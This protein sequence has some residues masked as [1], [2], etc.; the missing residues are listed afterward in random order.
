MSKSITI[1]LT[2][3][4][5]K[6]GPFT[7]SDQFGNI[8]AQDVPKKT[9]IAGVTYS[10]DD[11]VTLIIVKSV[12]SCKVEKTI[13]L[14][15]ITTDQFANVTFSQTTT[16]CIWRHLTNI[17]IYN[18]FYGNIE[19][20]IIEYPFAYSY[21]DEI[22][23]N[24]K[25]YTK[26]YEYLPIPDGVFNDNVRIE[27]NDKWFNKAILYNGQQSSGILE[28]VAKP[29]HNLKAYMQY[30]IF[31]A[32]SKTITY[33]KSDNFYQY[34]T[35]WALQKSSQVPMFKTSCESMSIDKVVNQDNMDYGPRSFKKATLR[36]KELKV[37]HILD[38]SS[39]THL[40][41]QFI[42]TPAQISYK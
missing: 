25:D 5:P 41:S 28:L 32:D 15:P 18:T 1:K 24:V 14:S 17:Q 11:N 35:F 20:Y 6:S 26:A 13:T 12:G 34:N 7:I 30:P 21:Q 9:L 10:L 40:V 27:T 3:A 29:L 31:N 33:T 4:G 8:I 39:T 22:L 23:Q 36:A 38:N 37:R 2:K 42:V 16:A 19:P